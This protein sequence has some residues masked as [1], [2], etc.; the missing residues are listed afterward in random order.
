MTKSATRI[1]DKD[2]N[3]RVSVVQS[4]EDPTK[5]WVVILN[6]DGTP[7]RGKQGIPWEAAT[8]AVW[9]TTTWLPGSSA[10]VVNSWTS[11]AA[12]FDFTI[13]Q[14]PQGEQ[15][16][17]G[18]G[19]ASVTSSKS[20]KITTVT[21]TETDWDSTSF[22]ISDW[23]DWE[24]SGDVIWPNSST[25][26][27][28][29]LF[30]WTTGKLIKDWSKS[31]SDLQDKLTAW[32]YIDISAGS[33]EPQTA[34][35]S[36]TI[37]TPWAVSLT[38]VTL[39]W[40]TEQRNLP[41]EYTQVEYLQSSG[42]QY[43]DMG[44]TVSS[45]DTF[46][47]KVN[48]TTVGQYALFSSKENIDWTVGRYLGITYRSTNVKTWYSRGQTTSSS[49]DPS[50]FTVSANTDYTIKI[51]P[52]LNKCTVNGTLYNGQ[53]GSQTTDVFTTANNPYLF[54]NNNVWTPSLNDY[55]K[56]YYFQVVKS[57]STYRLN[58][59]PCRRNSDNVLGMYDTVSGNFLTNSWTWTFTAG[60]DIVPSPAVPMN[61]VSNNG[62]LKVSPNLFD[63][64]LVF[65]WK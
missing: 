19:I 8:I 4:T 47:M 60:A 15:G 20:G 35:G 13:P 24:G 38:S 41:S 56:V 63:K 14:W 17:T 54:A 57:D 9:T 29:V 40:W 28:I 2:T 34:T 18:N 44:T 37:S 23:Q 55:V 64:N 59:I 52:S 61:I 33:W 36:N 53:G 7:I 62:V 48:W 50:T 31:L 1:Q 12:V 25:D 27:D 11:S 39:D 45:T 26:W 58:L 10:S 65:K 49:A 32:D 42:T 16:E 5:Y 30:D 21:I 3:K 51:Q 22:E 6:P 46:N 43:I